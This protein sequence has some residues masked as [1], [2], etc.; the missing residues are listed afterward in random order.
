M[1]RRWSAGILCTAIVLGIV[2]VFAESSVTEPIAY[3]TFHCIGL[4][5]SPPGGSPERDVLVRFREKGAEEWRLGLPMRYNP[6]DDTDEDLADYRGSIVHLQPN[7]TYEIELTLE[8][9]SQSARCECTTW[10]EHFP[11]GEIVRVASRSEPLVISESGTPDAWRVYD[12]TGAVIDVKHRHDTCITID[13]SYVIVRGFTLKGAGSESNKSGAPIG[14][15]R[16]DG[17]HDIVIEDCDISDWGRLDPERGFGVNMDSAILSRC[18]TLSRLI[19]QRCRMHHPTYDGSTW[20][21]PVHP[22]HTRGPQCISLFNTAGRHV[23]RY[24]E[25]YSDLEHMYN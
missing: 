9:T 15:V 17:G 5:W 14:A 8:G 21:E 11:E 7:T 23:I 4:Y 18:E 1:F 13:A 3:P 10:D 24:N 19:V 22:T 25:C 6:I 12:G 20:Y 16:I 2:S